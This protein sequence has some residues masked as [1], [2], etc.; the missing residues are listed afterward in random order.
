MRFLL[1]ICLRKKENGGI[2]N[3][4][5]RFWY[6]RNLASNHDIKLYLFIITAVSKSLFNFFSIN[7]F[8]QL[9]Y[10][11]IIQYAPIDSMVITGREDDNL[12]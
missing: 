6:L 12:L 11:A 5:E 1:I 9:W 2:L 7:D 4:N 10:A 3:R 8:E